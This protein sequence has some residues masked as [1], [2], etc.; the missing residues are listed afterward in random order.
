[1]R[2]RGGA[3]ALGRLHHLTGARC[4][5]RGARCAVRGLAG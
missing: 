2:E 3:R 4:A 5:V 1:V